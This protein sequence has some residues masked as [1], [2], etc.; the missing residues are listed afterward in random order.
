M[1]SVGWLYTIYIEKL[2]IS[3][4]HLIHWRNFPIVTLQALPVEVPWK[5]CIPALPSGC[6]SP[7]LAWEKI[8]FP[9]QRT[10]AGGPF[11]PSVEQ[12]VPMDEC[13]TW[14]IWVAGETSA[15]VE[16]RGCCNRVA[17]LLW[18]WILANF[19]SFGMTIPE[20]KNLP[21]CQYCHKWSLASVLVSWFGYGD[22]LGFVSCEHPYVWEILLIFLH[23]MQCL[24]SMDPVHVCS[25]WN[26]LIAWTQKQMFWLGNRTI[27]QV[28][29]LI[30]LLDCLP[31]AVCSGL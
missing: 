20:K 24:L 19:G 13:E 22:L 18:G 26:A 17:V 9:S 7:F 4:L 10:A 12:L 16:A 15:E 5:P 30:L 25:L 31:H 3:V 29:T 8:L 14:A 1:H 2:F 23:Q 27:I 21:R 11:S 6:P 28:L